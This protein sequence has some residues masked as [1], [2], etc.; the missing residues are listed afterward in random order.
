MVCVLIN[1]NSTQAYHT[2]AHPQLDQFRWTYLCP[3]PVDQLPSSPLHCLAKLGDP[4]SPSW[5]PQLKSKHKINHTWLSKLYP[6]E[7]TNSCINGK[8]KSR[9][10]NTPNLKLHEPFDQVYPRDPFSAPSVDPNLLN[11]KFRISTDFLNSNGSTEMIRNSVLP[12]L[13]ISLRWFNAAAEDTSFFL[14]TGKMPR[15]STSAGVIPVDL[16]NCRIV[17]VNHEPIN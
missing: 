14:F 7:S 16:H 11:N 13:R 8:C 9:T 10:R 4:C 6:M 17:D 1:I 2:A 3:P 15:R 5:Y 12:P